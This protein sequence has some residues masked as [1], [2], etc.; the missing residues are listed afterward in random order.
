MAIEKTIDR[1]VRSEDHAYGLTFA[2]ELPSEFSTFGHAFIIWQSE[3]DAKQM[4]LSEAIGFYPTGDP[5][6][7]S[8]IFGTAGDLQSDFGKDADLKMTVLL[9]LDLYQRA[10][11]TKRT[12]Q[13]DGRYSFL[14][15]N[16]VDHVSDIAKS[17]SLSTSLTG[18]I[19]PQ[20]YVQDL[21][22][23]NN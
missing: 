7:L 8:V 11:H 1:R 18:W 19:T 22:N 2:A 17:I 3:D 14:W 5:A 4:S 15:S 9:N 6:M 23:S 12:W 21:I 13:T 16:C 20:S 10:L